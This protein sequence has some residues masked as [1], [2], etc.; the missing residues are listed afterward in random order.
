MSYRLLADAVVVFHFA[1]VIFVVCGGLLVV[2]WRRVAWAHLPVAAWVIFAEWFHRMCPLTFL[3]NW[4]RQRAGADA[5]RGDFVSHYIIPVLYPE[6]LT[7]R[8]QIVLGT[9][10]FVTNVVLYAVAF[11]HRRRPDSGVGGFPSAGHS[12]TSY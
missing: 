4:L 3:E 12:G 11:H 2:R 5:Y 10:I 8:M 6:G 1:V 9:F 7:D